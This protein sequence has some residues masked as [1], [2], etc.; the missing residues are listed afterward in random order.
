MFQK[1]LIA[2]RG[3]IAVRIMRTCREMGIAT[4]AV[5]SEVDE[6]AL[7]VMSADEAVF[8]GP[9]EPSESY[10]NIEKIIAAAKETG[11]E[12][13]HPGY[14]FLAENAEFAKACRENEIVFI[15]PPPEV[16]EK[17]GDKIV[18]RSI[19][20][21]SGVPVTPGVTVDSTDDAAWAQAAKKIGYPVL[22]K[23]AAGG[24]G[25]GMRVVNS[26]EELPESCRMAESEARAAF[27]DGT[28]YMEKYLDR[29]RHVEIQILCDADGNAVHL[30]ER[31]CSIQ[32]RH[33]KIIE[34]TPSTA[35]T[36][37]LR[38]QMGNAAVAAAKASGYVNAGTVEFLLDSEGRFY[39]LEVN[40]RLQVEH[41][42]TEMITGTDLVRH[43]IEI[44]AGQPLSITQADIAGRGH[45]I[46]CRIYAE[47]PENQFFPSP[48][49][50]Q[51][52]QEP[53]GP[54]IRNDC[55][56][57]SGFEVPVE[58]DPI[59]SKLVVFAETRDLAIRRMIRA[60]E[61]YAIIGVKTP[62][63][64]LKDVLLSEPFQNGDTFT[65]FIESHF[66]EWAHVLTD[67]EL[68]CA[69]YLADVLLPGGGTVSS[70]KSVSGPPPLWQTLGNW[71]L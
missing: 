31:E 24:G 65:D 70:A 63:G 35:L 4:V 60:L 19:M 49:K 1:I 22:V 10:L 42:I 39:F 58:Y 69:A 20:S 33:Q 51:F 64:F 67:K 41:P 9:A 43:Q 28:I 38:T 66:A 16:I 62:V 21:E 8:L 50:I 47:D 6:C 29:S 2:N 30:L 5:Y 27:G 37:E 34:E 13:I 40:T 61:D 14:G 15:G 46:E 55:G 53:T 48:G 32:R 57:Y 25:K 36:D 45:A 23:A 17:L 68:A 12:A 3:E 44:A 7:H 11:A 52:I 71:R 18:A 54:G 56:V 26:S 59:L